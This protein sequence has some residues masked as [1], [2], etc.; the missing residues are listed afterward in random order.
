M[1]PDFNHVKGTQPR[2]PVDKGGSMDPQP[3]VFHYETDT[4]AHFLSP[5]I[6]CWRPEA[7]TGLARPSQFYAVETK[8]SQFNRVAPVR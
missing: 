5:S 3:S 4:M 1:V 7:V 2:Q 8:A 6:A